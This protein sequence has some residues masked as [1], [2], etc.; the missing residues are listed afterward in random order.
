M[1]RMWIRSS[2]FFQVH[3]SRTLSTS[4]MQLGGIH[5]MGG[6]NRSTPRTVA[7]CF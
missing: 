4:R 3:S 1:I 7:V 2:G 5:V 6:G